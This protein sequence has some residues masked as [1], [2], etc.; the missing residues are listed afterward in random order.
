MKTL[1]SASIGEN[2]WDL[3]MYNFRNEKV[4]NGRSDQ[5]NYTTESLDIAINVFERE[6]YET[7]SIVSIH[8]ECID[9]EGSTIS[10]RVILKSR[11][12]LVS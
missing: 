9:N 11:G 1:Y 3:S 12:S 10:S 7:D 6:I 5:D 8:E 2:S 4:D